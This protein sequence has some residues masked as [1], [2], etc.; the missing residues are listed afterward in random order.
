MATMLITGGHGALGS[1]V[2]EYAASAGWK[3]ITPT[4]DEYDLR[5]PTDVLKLAGTL[6][7]DLRA[8][9]HLVGG[10]AAGAPLEATSEADVHLMIDLNYR[11]AVNVLRAT[12]PLLQAHG[13]S[14]VTIGAQ[15]VMHPV[16]DKAVYASTKA[17]VAALTR[18][19]AEEGRA[20]GVRANCILPSIIRTDANLEWADA[21]TARDFVTPQEIA[22]TIVDLCRHDCGIN[23]AL[24][25]MYGNIPC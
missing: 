19:V 23:G 10:I 21:E 18:A 1:V 17:A 6:P 24:I 12:L 11:T 13:G 22:S 7:A 4:V 3:T 9:V 25:P 2:V 5:Q 14:I 16:V 8:V 20:Y 15:V